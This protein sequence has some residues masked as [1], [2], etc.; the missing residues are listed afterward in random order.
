MTQEIEIE[1]KN[2]LTKQEFHH[3]LEHL[4]FPKDGIKQVNYYFETKDFS[5]K[6]HWS[7]LRIREKANH[8]SLTLKEPLQE[9]LLETHDKITKEEKDAW[10][11]GNIIPKTNTTKRLNQLG[12]KPEELVF[13]GKLTTIRHEFTDNDFIYVLDQSIYNGITDYEIEIEAPDYESG[14]KVFLQVLNKYHI[15][16]KQTAN[17]IE[18]FFATKR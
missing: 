15:T 12:I 6:E 3:L 1:F 14:E 9:G 2:M 4:P 18:R 8:F 13:Y 17:K 16:R 5:L 10:I 7:A 11:N